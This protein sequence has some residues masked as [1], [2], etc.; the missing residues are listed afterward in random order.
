MT[1]PMSKEFYGLISHSCSRPRETG[2]RKHQMHCGCRFKCS[3]LGLYVC[4]REEGLMSCLGIWDPKEMSKSENF[5]ICLKKIMSANMLS[6][7]L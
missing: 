4:E 3:Q 6:E 1:P 2:K 7:N 5:P